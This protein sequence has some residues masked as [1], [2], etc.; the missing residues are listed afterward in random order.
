VRQRLPHALSAARLGCAFIYPRTSHLRSSLI[1]G[2]PTAK[3]IPNRQTRPGMSALLGA[4]VICGRAASPSHVS[5]SR[6]P[7]LRVPHRHPRAS[8]AHSLGSV[9]PAAQPI[10]ATRAGSGKAGPPGPAPPEPAAIRR[11]AA[12]DGFRI[13]RRCFSVPAP[14]LNV[15][16]L[17]LDPGPA[18]AQ[19]HSGAEGGFSPRPMRAFTPSGAPMPAFRFAPA[20]VRDDCAPRRGDGGSRKR[21]RLAG[22]CAFPSWYDS[23]RS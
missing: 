11:P 18:A 6:R 21:R 23:S 13:P 20:E 3:G 17:T 9:G 12:R 8:E 2:R 7:G 22:L 10:F 1:T 16:V 15:R 4:R 5:A 14:A 19:S